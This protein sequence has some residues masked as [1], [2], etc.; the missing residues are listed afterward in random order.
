MENKYKIVKQGILVTLTSIFML[1]FAFV[2]YFLLF[3][4]FEDS[5]STYGY[6]SFLRVGYG[7]LW[8]IICGLIYLTHIYDWLKACFLNVGISVFLISISVQLY[9][10]PLIGLLISGSI[11][12]VCLFIL[13]RFKMKWYH[14]YALLLSLPFLF[15]YI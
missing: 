3:R 7:L 9:D 2:I 11:F 4:L 10:K 15:I 8:L 1:G 12:I 13:I 14:F 6:V 5:R